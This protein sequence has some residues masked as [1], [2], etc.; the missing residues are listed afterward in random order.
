MNRIV[1]FL[2]C[3]G[4]STGTLSLEAV[5]PTDVPL[6]T[7]ES[8]HFIYIYQESL[9]DRIPK[10]IRDCEDAYT[11]L[12][13]IFQ[14]IP[15]ERVIVLFS[16]G[17][18][19]HNGW[20]TVFP[21]PTMMIYAGDTP[22]GSTIYE[23]GD[24]I[25]RT[26]FHEFTHLLSMDPQFGLDGALTRVFGRVL[27]QPG[28]PLSALITLL[29]LPPGGVAPLWFIE[30]LA[31][32][33]ETEM[34]GP[35]RGRNTLVD[36]I[37]RMAVAENRL[38]PPPQWDLNHPEWP[39]GN[40]AYLYGM[41][42]IQYAHETHGLG[43]PERNVVGEMS[44]SAADSVPFMF[45]SRAYPVTGSTFAQLAANSLAHER[46][47]Q[48][49]R[50]GDLQARPFTELE[51]R[52]PKALQVYHPRFDRTGRKILFS[53]APEEQ[54]N[55]L[56]RFDLEEG[57][58]ALHRLHRIRTDGAFSQ[59]APSPDRA[60]YYY[61]RLDSPR[62]EK[63]LSQLYQY[64][65]NRNRTRRIARTGRYRFP[66]IN[67]DH[68]QL[69]AIRAEAGRQVLLEVPLAHAGKRAHERILIQAPPD[70]TLIDPVYAPDGRTLVYIRA[71]ET[72]SH[73]QRL[74]LETGEDTVLVDWP[75]LITSPVFHPDGR[76]LVFVS[77]Q[78][79]V[80][81]LYRM[82]YRSDARPVAI[83]HALGGVFQPDFSP[84]GRQLAV[85]AY[86]AYGYYLALLDYQALQAGI[87]AMPSIE[88][89]WTPLPM[90]ESRRSEIEGRDDAVLAP[91][92]ERYRPVRAV[93]FNYWAPWLDASTDGVQGGLFFNASDPVERHNL[94]VIGGYE[95]EH[96]TPLASVVYDYAR[97]EPVLTLY[98]F[99]D[100]NRYGS[101]L[102]DADELFYDYDEELGGL[103]AVLTFPLER[104]DYSMYL[105]LGYQWSRSRSIRKT[106]D[107]FAEADLIT[108]PLFAGEEAAAWIQLEYLNATA[109]RRS[110]SLE[111]GRHLS[112]AAERTDEALGA[113]L[114]RTRTLAAWNEYVPLP[115]SDNH[116]LKL[117]GHYGISRGDR[118][119]QSAFGLGGFY[120]TIAEATPGMPRSLGLRGYEENTQVGTDIVKVGAAW[121]F[122]LTPV[123]RGSS[124][125]APF[126]MHQ[127]FGE[128]FYEGGRVTGAEP[129]G[130]ERNAWLNA[131][132]FELNIGLTL[133]RWIEVAPGV[134][135]VYAADRT[136]R[137]HEDDGDT[138]S[139]KWQ[140]Y[141]SVKSVVNF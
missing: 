97:L 16:D 71:D 129:P 32:W 58:G 56:Y 60:S 78:N 12:T 99:H 91:E 120:N 11:L 25:R 137:E 134:G 139:E 22:P 132:G 141:V 9:E 62:R 43:N 116:V 105:S 19:I 6:R 126:Y 93:R 69:A 14:W 5:M 113:E 135:V 104:A 23:P 85:S 118:T 110:H 64:D 107:A 34:V 63:L 67:R 27:P 115:W 57:E 127:L 24:Y 42:M 114:N 95:S 86:D 122:P 68:T 10:L 2:V 18:D 31:M 29:A 82:A 124:A 88:P 36:M 65:P 125:T 131:Y 77:D 111:D 28:D 101:L 76:E 89:T 39:F 98:G 128:L 112:L 4:M 35:G 80:Y 55:T 138:G 7:T 87:D 130:R 50:I 1:L 53:G 133:L 123:Y 61:T 100:Q 75:A 83:T 41:K 26:V 119:A 46:D 17:Y 21:R 38:L 49:Q 40:V 121:R 81:N 106:A 48:S 66:A 117:E 92:T 59:L 94:T 96:K 3:L 20:A 140:A 108:S 136:A 8:E 30:G 103:G 79:G 15:R 13:P 84:D 52:T 44:L 54:R 102:E 37:M 47:R 73:L 74:N 70:T 51:R 90:N 72:A 33:T 109:F 45:N